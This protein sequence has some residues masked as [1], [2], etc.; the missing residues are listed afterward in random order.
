[1]TN[2]EILT[3]VFSAVIAVTGVIGAIIFNNQLSV[4]QGQLNVMRADQRPW[5]SLSMQA[6]GPLVH[7][8]TGWSFLVKY[9]VA[10]VG[11]S[12]A[13]N[14][15]FVA[16]MIPW[17]PPQPNSDG[18]PTTFPDATA[19]IHAATENI[20]NAMEGFG[21]AAGY[22]QILFPGEQQ[23]QQFRVHP[24]GT[25][26]GTGFVRDFIVIGC[27]TYKFLGDPVTHRTVRIIDVSKSAYGQLIHLGGETIPL[28]G[29]APIPHPGGTFAN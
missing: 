11:K 3:L 21:G 20:C 19:D 9:S 5:I 17:G 1:M 8:A 18:S 28:E 24:N 16:T 23:G 10:N 13:A 26:A 29:L 14:V 22:G 27:A 15:D 25:I 12:P 7:D 6:D 4:M 2:A